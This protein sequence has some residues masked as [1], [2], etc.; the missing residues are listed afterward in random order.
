MQIQGSLAFPSGE[1]FSLT[2]ASSRP[3]AGAC[4]SHVHVIAAQAEYPMLAD[5]PYTPGEATHAMLRQHLASLG[6][7]RVVLVQPTVY[8][9][10]NRYLLDSL[11]HLG[12]SAR[13]VVVLPDPVRDETLQ[14][15]AAAG[16]RG[17]RL[18]LEK[19]GPNAAGP[20]LAAFERLAPRLVSLGW[21]LQIYAA[22]EIIA[23]TAS[24]LAALPLP[25]VL[26]HFAMMR[27]SH[28]GTPVCDRIFGLL[29][30]ADVWMK[31]SAAYRLST[32]EA[33]EDLD[34]LVQDLLAL[35]PDRL[36]WGTDWPHTNREPGK[37]P[38][39]VSRFREVDNQRALETLSR[40]MP[41]ENLRHA[42]LV[43]NPA[44]LYGFV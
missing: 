8:G 42:I 19:D 3:P 44:R 10:D 35:R 43:T 28:R 21:H 38:H 9:S 11:R 2:T 31:V 29:R 15:M 26:D 37:A 27:A 4:D 39:E 36:L 12:N 7:T 30:E 16:V 14:E 6:L 23:A 22:P 25:V 32:A 20:A 18:T 34:P 5:R 33:H 40:W 41:D 17:V 24:Q 13:G 1:E